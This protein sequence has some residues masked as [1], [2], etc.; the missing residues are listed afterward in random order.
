MK[1]SSVGIVIVTYNSARTIESCLDSV[2]A[3]LYP[4]LE[5][6]VVDNASTDNTKKIISKK[7]KKITFLENK[8]NVGFA[9]GNN[10]G[11]EI[12]MK[13]G[14][15][16][17]LL[18]NP[19]TEVKPHIIENL[20][21][22]FQKKDVGIVGC[23]ITYHNSDTIWFAGGSFNKYF[24]YTKHTKMNR[25]VSLLNQKIKETVFITGCCMMVRRSVFEKI[26]FLD[27]SFGFYFEDVDFCLRAYEAGYICKIIEKPLVSHRVSS[28]SGVEGSNKLTPFKAFYYGRNPFFIINKHIKGWKKVTAVFGQFFIRLPFHGMNMLKQKDF[29]ALFA[30]VRGMKEGLWELVA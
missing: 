24:C 23:A 11:I 20:L 28:S 7:N 16:F 27:S 6:V 13:K 4:N 14:I 19:D 2:S 10:L 25:P 12:F 15:E 8:K 29:R 5:V 9:A 21:E 26:G 30:F 17:I 3:I 18:L 22:P 1:N